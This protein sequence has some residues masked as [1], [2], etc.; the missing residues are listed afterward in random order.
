MRDLLH[1][2]AG[3]FAQRG[4]A[5]HAADALRQH[6][7]RRQLGQLRG[8]EVGEQDAVPGHPVRVHIRQGRRR[9]PAGGGVLT[10]DENLHVVTGINS[11]E[12]RE[13]T[14]DFCP[15]HVLRDVAVVVM[16]GQVSRQECVSVAKGATVL[17]A[18]C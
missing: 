10:T 14:D 15:V 6:C 3:G 12:G 17:R 13:G 7:V 2:R 8:P 9:D 18:R 16:P 4:D 1:V 11:G 5:V